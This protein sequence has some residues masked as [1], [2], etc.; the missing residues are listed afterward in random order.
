MIINE[1]IAERLFP[2]RS[3]IG[4]RVN[5]ND[6]ENPVWREIVG[7]VEDIKNFGIRRPSQYA[8]YFPYPQVSS[9][10]LYL[11]IRTAGDPTALLPSV[12]SAVAELDRGLAVSN[13]R[14]MDEIV[15]RSLAQD[16]FVAALLSGFAGL[17]LLLAAV[18]LY[19]VVAY[20]VNRRMREL[21]V[22]IAVGA[23]ERDIRRLII[24]GSMG[25]VAI[26]VAIGVVAAALLTRFLESLLFG[27]PATDP[28]TYLL[29]AVLLAAVALLASAM[30]AER[31]A[32]IDPVLVLKAE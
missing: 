24:G 23:A 11:V 21:G 14:P 25:L 31:A 16:R 26:G 29:V 22:R 27:V 30:P 10:V 32:R 1:T 17:A 6:P 15:G 18:G 9:R 8:M 5:L 19:G 28:V 12:R 7:V 4:Q 2:D 20:S 3:P 13:P